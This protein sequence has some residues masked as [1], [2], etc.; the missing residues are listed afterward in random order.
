VCDKP[1]I[2][3]KH[4]AKVY[5]QNLP[6][7]PTMAVPHLDTRILDGKKTLL[8]GPF[9]AWT[10]RFLHRTGSWTDLPRSIKPHNVTTLLKIAATNFPLMKY[11]L[12]QG[13]Q[14]MADRMR[15]LHIFYPNAKAEDWKLVDGG[16][17]VQAIKKTDGEAGIVHFGTEVLTS[18][19]KSMSALL[20]ASPG[21]SVC[22]NIVTEV[23]RKS[24]P[25]LTEGEEGR[26]RL[27]S[28]IPTYG[29]DY[30]LPENAAKFAELQRKAKAAL[31][32]I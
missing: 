29:I 20:G 3:A 13:T 30:R 32:L 14:S 1:E 15:V 31:Q 8:F 19:D 27:Q 16:I 6:E 10:T 22:V 24:F 17:R 4:Q 5:G 7:A 11:L 21:A 26:K 2:V 23:I 9:A 18:A 12:Q 28:I 25:H